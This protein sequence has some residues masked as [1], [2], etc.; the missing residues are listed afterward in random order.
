MN[1]RLW[2]FCRNSLKLINKFNLNP[3]YRNFSVLYLYFSGENQA[4]YNHIENEIKKNNL[5]NKICESLYKKYVEK[6]DKKQL[7]EIYEKLKD[8][9]IETLVKIN[10]SN[11]NIKNKNKKFGEYIEKIESKNIPIK[12]FSEILKS[13]VIELKDFR[14]DCDELSLTLNKSSD[15]IELLKKKIEELQKKAEIDPLTGLL[16]RRAFDE[17]I[18][19][20]TK[21]KE[22]YPISLIFVDIDDF[23]HINDTH[24]HIIGDEVLRFIA[25]KLKDNSKNQD[26][27]ARFGGEEFILLLPN[28]SLENAVKFAER[29][30][31]IISSKVLI[32]KN[33]RKQIGKITASFGVSQ[34]K[35]NEPISDFIDRADKALY[36][37]KA[38]GKNQVNDEKVLINQKAS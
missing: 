6:I 22:F 17:K 29:L 19:E 31:D 10:N 32:L 15:D 2:E 11:I 1:E 24:G 35:E 3:D 18:N 30:K 21:N 25:K 23:K 28:T 9:L 34:Y 13:V 38:N 16:N 12:E 14:N 7:K 36:F 27:I 8:I 26:I 37:S 5:N 33:S 20:I 4:L